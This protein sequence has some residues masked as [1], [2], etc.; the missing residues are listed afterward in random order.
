MIFELAFEN[1][2]FVLLFLF[3]R[4]ENNVL[5]Q[6]ASKP[7]HQPRVFK[8]KL[9]KEDSVGSNFLIFFRRAATRTYLIEEVVTP[10]SSSPFCG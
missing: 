8:S 6:S 3:Q 9:S 1:W 4:K 10:R 2:T 5:W 7:K